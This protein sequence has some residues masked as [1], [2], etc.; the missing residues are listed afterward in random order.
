LKNQPNFILLSIDANQKL[1]YERALERNSE[2]DHIDFEKFK[3]Q[4]LLES[5]NQ[6]PNKGNILACQ[7]LADIHLENNKT[8]DVLYRQIDEAFKKLSI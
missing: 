4:E 2:K 7:A 1:R 6:D 5:S 8:P 3:E